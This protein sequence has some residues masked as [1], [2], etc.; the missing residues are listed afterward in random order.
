[1]K[2]VALVSLLMG[3]KGQVATMLYECTQCYGGAQHTHGREISLPRPH[4]RHQKW[5]VITVGT[6]HGKT[7]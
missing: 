5:G 7:S 4:P 1:M 2:L 3:R 6:H